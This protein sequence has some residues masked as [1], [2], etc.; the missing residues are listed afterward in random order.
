MLQAFGQH[1]GVAHLSAGLF[2]LPRF[3]MNE[4]YGGLDRLKLAINALPLEVID[5]SQN[6]LLNT[7]SSLI[8]FHTYKNNSPKNIVR[9]FASDK[10]DKNHQNWQSRIEVRLNRC[11]S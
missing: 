1:S 9:C 4:N 3:A 8:W 10:I 5:V 2:E 6:P 7:K 11:L